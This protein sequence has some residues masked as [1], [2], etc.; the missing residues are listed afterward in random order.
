MVC[1]L[2][3]GLSGFDADLEQQT[4]DTIWNFR[5]M[6]FACV[7]VM[8]LAALIFATLFPLRRRDV[9]AAQAEL[10]RRQEDATTA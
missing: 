2:M 10:A 7:L 9:E 4:P 6:L 5:V 3:L 8:T 1:M